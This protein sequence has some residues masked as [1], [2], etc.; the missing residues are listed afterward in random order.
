MR[1]EER[2][3]GRGQRLG[4]GEGKGFEPDGHWKGSRRT[5]QESHLLSRCHPFSLISR[6]QHAGS[7]QSFDGYSDDLARVPFTPCLRVLVP[8]APV[9]SPDAQKPGAQEHTGGQVRAKLLERQDIVEQQEGDNRSSEV[10]TRQ[11]RHHEAREDD[12]NVASVAEK[13]GVVFRV[14][15]GLARD[16]QAGNSSLLHGGWRE[17]CQLSGDEGKVGGR[18]GRRRLMAEVPLPLRA[19][20][21]RG[22]RRLEGH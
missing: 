6:P 8:P 11:R 4:K 19:A 16:R 10:S 5:R 2:D 14:L 15:A 3:R 22:R 12:G 21:L 17:L 7:L 1:R 9:A 20:I 13:S 18:G